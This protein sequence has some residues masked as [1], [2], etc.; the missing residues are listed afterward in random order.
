MQSISVETASVTALKETKTQKNKH[1]N[2]MCIIKA[3]CW[4]MSVCYEISEPLTPQEVP[5][6]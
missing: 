4:I 2:I 5:D 6:E 1:V 3:E